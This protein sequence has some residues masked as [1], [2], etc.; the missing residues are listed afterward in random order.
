MGVHA[1]I[2]H[3]PDQMNALASVQK[4]LPVGE[5][6]QTAIGD[7]IGNA[8]Q[9]LFE[10]APRTQG[11]MP[12]LGIA[13]LPIR[14]THGA[15]RGLQGS[16]RM[17]G[18]IMIEV[19][20]TGLSPSIEGTIGIQAKAVKDHQQNFLLCHPAAPIFAHVYDRYV[21]SDFSISN[22][23]RV[24]ARIVSG[25]KLIESIPSRTR[26]SAISG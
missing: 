22:T 21:C 25:F 8:Q 1:T 11:Q 17:T 18:E 14:K 10:D 12:Y 13:K 7:G 23:C 4:G 15:S 2:R 20:G 3:H 24:V 9:I 6:F 5:L 16:V 26:Y 19:R